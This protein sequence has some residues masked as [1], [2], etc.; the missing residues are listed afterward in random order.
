MV[1]LAIFLLA[2]EFCTISTAG[3][4]VK[5]LQDLTVTQ[6][7]ALQESENRLIADD[8]ILQALENDR[9]NKKI[10]AKDF[11][12]QSHDLIAYIGAE[13]QFQNAILTKQHAF[14]SVDLPEGAV[15]VLRTIGK[16]TLQISVDALCGFLKSGGNYSL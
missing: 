6:T 14:P 8:R 16:Y 2:F 15:K 12:W 3:A 1:R 9:K 7:L 4:A 11:A 5:S 10:S 13:A